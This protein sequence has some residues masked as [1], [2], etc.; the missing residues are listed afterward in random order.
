MG[1]EDQRTIN[2]IDKKIDKLFVYNDGHS[3]MHTDIL[4]QAKETNGRVRSL[5]ATRQE[6]PPREISDKINTLAGQVEQLNQK[7]AKC[8]IH[9]M[10]KK[11]SFFSLLY[12]HPK[13]TRLAFIGFLIMV[14][15]SIASAVVTYEKLSH[16]GNT[17]NKI[18]QTINN[19]K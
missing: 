19:K 12:D 7:H 9:E 16:I 1:P 4:I 8:P 11:I 3:K 10:E 15:T 5:E 17:E 2:D 13:F 6:Y 18:E 14:L